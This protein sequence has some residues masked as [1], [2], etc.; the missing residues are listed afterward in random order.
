MHKQ[1]LTLAHLSLVICYACNLGYFCELTD[2]S[3]IHSLPYS[4]YF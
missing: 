1:L 2:T 3:E 4:V